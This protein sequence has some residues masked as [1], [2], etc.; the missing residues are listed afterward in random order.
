MTVGHQKNHI[1]TEMHSDAIKHSVARNRN[2]IAEP[3]LISVMARWWCGCRGF[4][5]DKLPV[6]QSTSTAF[7]T[8]FVSCQ[9]FFYAHAL[10]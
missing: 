3:A 6:R 10:N 4:Y 9:P 8:A 1:S 5:Q 2:D 7:A